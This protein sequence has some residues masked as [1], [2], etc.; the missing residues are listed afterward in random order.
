MNIA[1][2]QIPFVT[3]LYVSKVSAYCYH[4]VNVI[5]LVLAQSDYIKW[6]TLY[7]CLSRCHGKL[8]L[9]RGYQSFLVTYTGSLKFSKF[10]PKT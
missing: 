6:L 2:P 7:I 8:F 10:Y 3:F 9:R 1:N 5:S 4:S